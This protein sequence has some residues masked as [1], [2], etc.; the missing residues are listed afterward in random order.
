MR[1]TEL[2][3]EYSKTYD[4]LNS[5]MN[6]FMKNE[7][8]PLPEPKD[9]IYHEAEVVNNYYKPDKSFSI[10]LVKKNKYLIGGI[11]L[12]VLFTLYYLKPSYIMKPKKLLS[13]KDEINYI[14]LLIYSIVFASIIF[15]VWF[16]MFISN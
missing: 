13:D 6:N 14:K 10:D 3:S 16:Y 5:N 9:V 4:R 11:F 12:I 1:H 2:I 7:E 8:I 15:G